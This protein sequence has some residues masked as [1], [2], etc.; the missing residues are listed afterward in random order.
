[1]SRHL[2]RAY[3]PYSPV[4]RP[5][6]G[7]AALKAW[8]VARMGEFTGL[9]IDIHFPLSYRVH[10]C[11]LPLLSAAQVTLNEQDDLTYLAWKRS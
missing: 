10:T 7:S 4:L 1:M 11:G 6:L 8:P 5:R 9:L 3:P 2:S